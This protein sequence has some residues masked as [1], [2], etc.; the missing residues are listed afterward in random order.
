MAI[1]KKNTQDLMIE[2]LLIARGVSYSCVTI[3]EL[4]TNPD[5]WVCDKYKVT[6]SREGKS[7]SFDYSC[8]IGHRINKLPLKSDENHTFRLASKMCNDKSLRQKNPSWQD[9]QWLV[10]PSAASVLYCLLLDAQ[11]GSETFEDFCS[12][13]GYDTD[14]RKALETYLACQETNTKLRFF[15]GELRSQF[16]EILEDY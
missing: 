7:I 6:F 1:L 12:N 8:G 4:A 3:E 13:C 11:C 10:I 16:E 9:R 5:G 14:S 2:K 15:S